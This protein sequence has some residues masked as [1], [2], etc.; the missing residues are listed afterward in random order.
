MKTSQYFVGKMMLLLGAIVIGIPLGIIHGLILFFKVVISHPYNIYT[1]SLHNWL[2]ATKLK[3]GD[4][5]DKHIARI[6]KNK[7]NYDN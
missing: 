7:N 6:E 3:E 4:I 1:L 2:E 5:W